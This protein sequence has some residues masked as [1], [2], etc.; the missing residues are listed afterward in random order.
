MRIRALLPLI[1]IL[2]APPLAGQAGAASSPIRPLPAMLAPA[3]ATP[4]IAIDRKAAQDPILLGGVTGMI[5][6]AATGGLYGAFVAEECECELAPEYTTVVLA[7]IGGGLG[8]IIGAL[9]SAVLPRG[10][11][12]TAVGVT[13]RH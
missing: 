8:G 2:A 9:T 10:D 12:G 11:G 3:A 13:L 6:G 4:A 7:V 5:V 1:A